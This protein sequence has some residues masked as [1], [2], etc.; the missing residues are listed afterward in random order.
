MAA[1]LPNQARGWSRSHHFLNDL[2]RR[3]VLKVMSWL[4]T[5]LLGLL[6]GAPLIAFGGW[7]AWIHR[8]DPS[9]P[10][11]C[12]QHGRDWGSPPLAES[13]FAPVA[14]SQARFEVDAWR[15]LFHRD[16][17]LVRV[18]NAGEGPGRYAGYS[19]R[20]P[21][22]TSAWDLPTGR[23]EGWDWCG[24]GLEEHLLLP[25]ESI[26][27]EVRIREGAQRAEYGIFTEAGKVW[28]PP[29]EF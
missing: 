13:A 20:Y 19:H 15:C 22:S 25:G 2:R 3:G 7:Q 28:A 23:E 26:H 14:T 1:A 10:S 21:Q 8:E 12:P 11:S 27:F 5:T 24:T 18:A 6:L 16:K 9:C 4:R 17:L 29:V